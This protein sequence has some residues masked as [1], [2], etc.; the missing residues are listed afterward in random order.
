MTATLFD[1]L[2]A[3]H[4]VADDGDGAG[5]I[6]VDRVMLH[7][8]TGGVA[9]RALAEAGR[10]PLAP[11]RVFAVMDH[12]VSFRSGRGR[13]EARSPGGANFI[14]ETRAM[15][16][17]A[18]VNLVDTDDARQGIVHVIAPELAVA[19]PGV[20]IICP[21]SHTCSLGALGAL[22]IGVG[23]SVAEHAM[24]TGVMRVER[25]EQM[26]IRVDGA[27]D[28][29]VTAK[30]L[31]LHIISA[32]GADGA[33]RRVV[34]Y[35]GGAIDAL[36]IEERL[37]L[38]NLAVEFAAFTA[39]IAPDE[40]VID[41]IKGRPFAP[42]PSHWDD[43]EKGWRAL[44]SDDDAEYDSE[45]LI[46]AA[47]VKP[48]IS[49][50]TSPEQCTGV[51]GVVPAVESLPSHKREQAAKAMTYM[52]VSPNERI[53]DLCVDGVFIGSCTNGRL[54]DLR[55]AAEVLRGRKVAPGLRAVCVP[56]S[57]AV[58]RAAEAEG[59]DAVFMA[60][61]FEWGEP[62]CAMCFYAG[63]ETFPPGSRVVSS[64]NRN[65]EGRQGPGVRTHLASPATV[66]A[67][68][69]KGKIAGAFAQ[70]EDAAT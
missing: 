62:G 57:K 14:T 49:W 23:S 27:L 45:I 3:I 28:S 65:F 70:L 38:C 4:A 17:D 21:D 10:A 1:K 22:A 5:L 32:Y 58:R 31:A 53:G 24:A 66:A 11:G 36:S 68:A 63:G 9:L 19:Y 26:R 18:G 16:T 15:A 67:S 13:D 35:A 29:G 51:N 64:T 7:E 41:Y 69:V 20:S 55:A 56:G 30:D 2:W 60:A 8:R 61:G 50:G 6:A 42:A 34:E 48:M 39:L 59:I 37:T 52:D 47:S 33:R 54:S 44:R 25:P 46:N 12:I 40:K 43:V